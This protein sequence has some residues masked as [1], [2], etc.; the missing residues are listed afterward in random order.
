MSI[1]LNCSLG[2]DTLI[3]YLRVIAEMADCAV[4]VHPNAG[5]PNELGEYDES[6]AKMAS[7][8]EEYCQEGLVNIVGGCCGTTPQHIEAIAEVAKKYKPRPKQIQELKHYFTGLE[9]LE[10]TEESLFVNVGERTNVAGSRK[11]AKL[12]AEKQYDKALNIAKKQVING[13]QILDINMDDALLDAKEEMV[14]FT[15]LL[16]TEPEVA[17]IPF[18]FDSSKFEVCREA[19]ACCPGTR[20]CEFHFPQRRP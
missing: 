2:A 19:L 6:A 14:H 13:A 18:M 12:I 10:L 3:N 5:L 8:I 15:N 20:N 17:R 11:F 1:G 16:A 4:N 9:P 7:A